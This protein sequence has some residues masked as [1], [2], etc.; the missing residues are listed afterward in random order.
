MEAC[1]V[2]EALFKLL[3][4]VFG[5]NDLDRH[6]GALPHAAIDLAVP[7]ASGR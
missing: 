4:G 5:G 1:L 3:G 2:P 6:F 7:E